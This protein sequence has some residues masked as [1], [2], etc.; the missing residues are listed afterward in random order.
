MGATI[1]ID[2]K[3][4]FDTVNHDILFSKLE[5]IGIF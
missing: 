4:S 3:K 5:N 2:H 1:F